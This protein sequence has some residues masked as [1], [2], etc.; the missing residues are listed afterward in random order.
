MNQQERNEKKSFDNKNWE[1]LTV[2]GGKMAV[3]SELEKYLSHH[4]LPKYGEK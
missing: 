1:E 3:T 2:N 4:N